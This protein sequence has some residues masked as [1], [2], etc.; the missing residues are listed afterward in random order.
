MKPNNSSTQN[1]EIDLFELISTIWKKKFLVVGISL[2]FAIA[3]YIYSSNQPK[4]YQTTISVIKAQDRMFEKYNTFFNYLSIP[5]TSTPLIVEAYNIEFN[6]KLFSTEN[7]L[8][9]VEQSKKIDQFKSYLKNNNKDL[10][11]YLKKN[12]EFK[13]EN[14]SHLSV[15]Q[16]LTFYTLNYAEPLL[17]QNFLDDYIIFTKEQ[18]DAIFAEYIKNII[19]DEINIL[20]FNYEIAKKIEFENLALDT[21]KISESKDSHPIYNKGTKVI[22][23]YI[24]IFK[25]ILAQENYKKNN[26][27]PI[28]DSSTSVIIIKKPTFYISLISFFLGFLL[29]LFIVIIRENYLN[30]IAKKK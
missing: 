14:N 18:V 21:R 23:E 1:D 8:K 2:I 19:L 10:S 28:L 6:I 26:Y 20:E 29:S 22:S 15:S 16:H 13:K 17:Y 27:N 4:I 11:E 12:F 25:R 30:L 7:F 24:V 3:G 9:F 5:I